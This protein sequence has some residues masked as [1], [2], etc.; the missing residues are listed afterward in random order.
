MKMKMIKRYATRIGAVALCSAALCTAPMLAQGGGG[1]GRGPQMTPD[2]QT[3]ALD[4]AVTLTP[5]QKTK[6]L[7]MY[8]ADA[9]KLADLRAAQ[10]PDMRTK[11]QAIRTDEQTQIKGWLTA[12]QNTK[13]TAYLAAMPQGRGGGGRG[14]GGGGGGGMGGGGAPPPQM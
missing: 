3:D 9:K 14:A 11:N 4:K 6:V 10:D 8:T 7:A 5:D 13:Y 1:G 12:D 2:Q